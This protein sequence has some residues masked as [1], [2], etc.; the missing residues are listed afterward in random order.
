MTTL[1][2]TISDDSKVGL[3]LSLLK[4][5]RF[6]KIKNIGQSTD[7]QSVEMLDIEKFDMETQHRIAESIAHHKNGDTSNLIEIGS[8]DELNKVFHAL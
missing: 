2:L 3:L 8:I 6:V 7:N 5:F 4:E 1:E